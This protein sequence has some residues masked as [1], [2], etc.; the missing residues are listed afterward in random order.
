MSYESSEFSDCGKPVGIINCPPYQRRGKFESASESS[1]A[2]FS[3]LCEDN[4]KHHDRRDKKRE[5]EWRSDFESDSVTEESYTERSHTGSH[6]H[7]SHSDSYT[8]SSRSGGSRT[9]GSRTGASRSQESYT[10]SS[11][12]ESGS[13]VYARRFSISFSC[14]TGHPWA[15]YNTGDMSVHVAGRDGRI[16][17]GPTLH[18]TRGVSYYFCV[19][20]NG[21]HNFALTNSPAGGPGARALYFQPIK[22]GCAYFRPDESTPRYLY[23]QDFSQSFAGG[24]IV[25]H[26]D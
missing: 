19:E 5:S 13:V 9:G 21:I 14:K 22:S 18:L 20:E 17:N 10:E 1:C 25:I 26:D 15:E 8:E 16:H 24:L 11:N 23:Y 7:N 2:D 4:P 3:R 12:S 6:S